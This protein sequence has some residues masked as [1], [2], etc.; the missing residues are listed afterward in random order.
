MPTN[1]QNVRSVGSLLLVGGF[2]IVSYLPKLEQHFLRRFFATSRTMHRIIDHKIVGANLIHDA[3][4]PFAPIL[5]EVFLH[6]GLV[7]LL[8]SRHDVVW[9]FVD[10]RATE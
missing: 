8:E 4:I 7:L 1:N 9:M 10:C 3:N 5:F 2:V 6:H